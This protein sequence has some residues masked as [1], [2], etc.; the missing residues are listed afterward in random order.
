M[1]ARYA[2]PSQ[3]FANVQ[4]YLRQRR[5]GG[6]TVTPRETRLAWQGYYDALAGRALQ[7]RQ[8]G[9]QQQQ[10]D[11]QSQQFEEQM[12]LKKEAMAREEDAA[13]IAGITELGSTAAMVGMAYPGISRAIGGGAQ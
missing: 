6:Q 13:R 8:L 4:R 2:L 3:S 5:A 12:D 11:I 10:L 7:Q 1:A 9:L